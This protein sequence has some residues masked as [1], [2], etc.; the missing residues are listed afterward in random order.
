MQDL[1]ALQTKLNEDFFAAS[2]E[3]C[4][5]LCRVQDVT[6]K[7]K[8]KTYILCAC[9]KYTKTFIYHLARTYSPFTFTS[10]A[11]ASRMK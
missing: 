4:L 7:A 6:K 8:N 11:R 5:A 10:Y 2:Q 1:P 3:T 9:S